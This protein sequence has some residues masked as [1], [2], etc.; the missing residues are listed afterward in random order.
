MWQFLLAVLE[1]VDNANW[2]LP[3]SVQTK[4]KCVCTVKKICACIW[5]KCDQGEEAN[6]VL[7]TAS[8]MSW[9]QKHTIRHK[10]KHTK[11][12]YYLIVYPDLTKICVWVWHTYTS[13]H[14]VLCSETNKLAWLMLKQKYTG[15]LLQWTRTFPLKPNNFRNC[16][17]KAVVK[18]QICG[19][20][21]EDQHLRRSDKKSCWA[22]GI[23]IWEE[24]EK[25]VE[26][27]KEKYSRQRVVVV[28]SEL[29]TWQPIAL[30]QKRSCLGKM[31]LL[32]NFHWKR[33]KRG[34]EKK[35]QEICNC[36]T[37]F[38]KSW[39]MVVVEMVERTTSR[40][41]QGVP[42]GGRGRQPLGERRFPWTFSMN[43]LIIIVTPPPPTPHLQLLTMTA[44]SFQ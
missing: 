24:V 40:R 37:K 7:I 41:P 26:R 2:V 39:A 11:V 5:D 21:I 30:D 22:K 6:C 17:G 25:K 27:P 32:W 38:L 15:S 35:R 31:A 29:S 23:N 12:F 14:D 20:E 44:A 42:G 34:Q 13:T 16:L 33:D 43:H 28:T 4:G 36:I 1:K 10:H 18:W 3:T 19:L 8:A 9:G